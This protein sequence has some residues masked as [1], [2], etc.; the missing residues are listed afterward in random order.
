MRNVCRIAAVAGTT[1]V[2]EEILGLVG[3]IFGDDFTGVP[4]TFADSLSADEADLFLCNLKLVD[5]LAAQ[6]PVAMILGVDMIPMPEFFVKMAALPADETRWVF[7]N[8]HGTAQVIIDHCQKHGLPADKFN[9]VTFWDTPEAELGENLGKARYIVGVSAL[10]NP[11]KT[12]H[13]S[14]GRYLRP[15]VTIIPVERILAPR[16]VAAI[17]SWMEIR[18]ARLDEQIQA[19]NRI[20]EETLRMMEQE[21]DERERIQNRLEYESTHDGLTDIYNRRFFRSAMDWLDRERV[22]PAAMVMVD[23]DGLKDI[24]DNFGHGEGDRVLQKAAAILKESFRDIDIVARVG[25]DEFA[26]LTVNGG[27]AEVRGAVWRIKQLVNEWARQENRFAVSVS[28][29]HAVAAQEHIPAEELFAAADAA[30]YADKK[31]KTVRGK[32]ARPASN[33]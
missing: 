5:N 6:I 20:L 16:S 13:T 10:V 17:K 18:R 22:V 25:G 28:V 8:T 14:Y 33:P 12:L 2:A 21:L 26:A 11:G 27:E 4:H 1:E 9:Y 3:Q 32:R 29:G 7:C 24:N 23:L 30:M 19:K 31:R 15:D